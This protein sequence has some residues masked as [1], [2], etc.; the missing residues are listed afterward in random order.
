[1]VGAFYALVYSSHLQLEGKYEQVTHQ[2]LRQELPCITFPLAKNVI[3]VPFIGLVQP[4]PH[5]P[6]VE[7]LYKAFANMLPHRQVTRG[8]GGA[9]GWPIAIIEEDF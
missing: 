7:F 3:P 8:T 1:L 2:C 9:E 4:E 6:E 5:P